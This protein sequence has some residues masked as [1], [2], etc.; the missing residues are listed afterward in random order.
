MYIVVYISC[1]EVYIYIIHTLYIYT[2]IYVII[3]YVHHLILYLVYIILYIIHALF[4]LH[5]I[6]IYIYIYTFANTGHYI[7][8]KVA[9]AAP[10]QHA[11]G[12]G[13]PALHYWPGAAVPRQLSGEL[14]MKNG[15]VDH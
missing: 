7:F 3:L 13:A 14:T 6:S 8:A 5:I 15:W 12:A 9:M 10:V 1:I 2:E 11:M 4:F